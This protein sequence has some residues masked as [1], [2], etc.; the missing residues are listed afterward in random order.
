MICKYCGS[1]DIE[2]I[3]PQVSECVP[4]GARAYRNGREPIQ[5]VPAIA[6]KMARAAELSVMHPVESG[7]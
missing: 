3:H 5:W 7:D 1:N 6:V 4:C 2:N